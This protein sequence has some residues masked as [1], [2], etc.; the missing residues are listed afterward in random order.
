MKTLKWLINNFRNKTK[1]TEFVADL[2]VRWIDEK[3]YE[4]INDYALAFENV[5][6]IK[7]V[8]PTEKPFGFKFK[9]K[10]GEKILN[11]HVFCRNKGK[12]FTILTSTKEATNA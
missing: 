3:D 4:D 6:K 9:V 5:F 12:Y 11:A 2:Y 8:T 10:N 1:S 7:N